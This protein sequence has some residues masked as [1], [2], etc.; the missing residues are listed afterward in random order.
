[1]DLDFEN[2]FFPPFFGSQISGFPGSQISKIQPGPSR[3]WALGLGPWALGR[4]GPRGPGGPS[5]GSLGGPSG[6]SSGGPSSLN[7]AVDWFAQPSSLLALHMNMNK[8]AE[9]FLFSFTKVSVIAFTCV[10][11]CPVI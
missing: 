5:G 2:F 3:V 1:M 10:I 11:F 4:V 6:G 8:F 9:A 7:A